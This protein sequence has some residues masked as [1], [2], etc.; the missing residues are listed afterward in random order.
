MYRP[1]AEN[2]FSMVEP[3]FESF[4]KQATGWSKLGAIKVAL[5]TICFAKKIFRQAF[6][7]ETLKYS[8][9]QNLGP[10]ELIERA[11]LQLLHFFAA[12]LMFQKTKRQRIDLK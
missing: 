5:I 7:D 4:M 10:N 12:T 11:I 2:K 9:L 1:A 8:E 3:A 6:K